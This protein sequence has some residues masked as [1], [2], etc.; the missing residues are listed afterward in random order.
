MNQ[1]WNLVFS[2]LVPI[3]AMLRHRAARASTVA[4]HVLISVRTPED[5][6]YA[7]ELALLA[8]SP[9]LSLSWTYT[10]SAPE[11]WGNVYRRRVD[12]EML[13]EVGPAPSES[14]RIYVCGPTPF[15]ETVATLLVDA[16]HSPRTVR[17]ER[18]GPTGGG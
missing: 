1:F 2:G 11:G 18:F 16:G 13:T 8:D 4:T 6:L 14:P 3:M 12:A 10:R 15:V 17:A 7:H 9:G 5:R